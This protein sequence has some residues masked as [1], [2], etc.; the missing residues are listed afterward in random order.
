[1]SSAVTDAI[2]ATGVGILFCVVAR[3]VDRFIPDTTGTH[4]PPPAVGGGTNQ[5]G[6]TMTE[7]LPPPD[8]SN[9][10][11]RV[12]QVT[13]RTETRF[14]QPVPNPP[15]DNTPADNNTDDNTDTEAG[16]TTEAGADSEDDTNA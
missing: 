14:G 12:E 10:E 16:D 2:I 11:S 1:M 9:G 6:T 3:L 7:T 5:K 8:E 4:P 15:A 13:E